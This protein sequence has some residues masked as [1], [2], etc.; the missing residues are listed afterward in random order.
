MSDRRMHLR[1]AGSLLL[2]AGLVIGTAGPASA[3]RPIDGNV[4]ALTVMASSDP[5]AAFAKLSDAQKAAYAQ[6]VEVA[7]ADAV[8]HD[9]VMVQAP[10]GK[11][12]P[13]SGGCWT[14]TWEV[15]GK[16]LGGYVVF[17]YF[18]DMGWCSNGSTITSITWKN[19]HAETDFLG[20]NFSQVPTDWPTSGGVG[21][22][23]WRLYTQ[24]TFSFCLPACI[25]WRYPWLDM[26]AHANG[27]GTGS[28][29][30]A[31]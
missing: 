15:D 22:S 11:V 30:G 16:S 23:S 13:L 19:R 18:Q 31:N 12:A 17:R 4:I 7:S 10:A 1:R 2:A 26:T 9:P 20:W 14:W 24:G 3:A 6:A 8:V 25:Q 28:V 29:G 21:S 27:T 5:S